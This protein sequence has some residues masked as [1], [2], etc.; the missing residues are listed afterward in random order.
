MFFGGSAPGGTGVVDQNINGPHALHRFSGQ[1]ADVFFLAA[2]GRDPAGIN[3][4]GLQ[5]GGGLFQV[6]RF[7]R[8]EHD[9]G[10]RLAQGMGHLQTQPARA[11]GDQSHLAGQVKKLL[12]G[13]CHGVFRLFHQMLGQ[14]HVG[15]QGVGVIEGV[16]GHGV[17]GKTGD[18]HLGL[19]VDVNRLA[20]DA[21]R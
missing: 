12:D 11:A 17:R 8:T 4:C 13:A 20:M 21:T 10:P 1:A 15:R 7:A 5:L 18:H 3:A 16:V 19:G 14:S 6:S 9:L 2:V